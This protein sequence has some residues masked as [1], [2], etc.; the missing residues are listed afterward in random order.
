MDSRGV[1]GTVLMDLPPKGYDCIPHDLFI[2]KLEAVG[3]YLWI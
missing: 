1:V 2:A 3:G